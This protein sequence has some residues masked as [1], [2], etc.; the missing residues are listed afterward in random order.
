MKI[1]YFLIAAYVFVGLNFAPSLQ[2]VTPARW[3]VDSTITNNA[4]FPVT[5]VVVFNDPVG[6][7][8]LNPLWITL[9]LKPKEI[10]D[11]NL[12]RASSGDQPSIYKLARV[13][14]I[15]VVPNQSTKLPIITIL[16]ADND[17]PKNN[18]VIEFDKKNNKITIKA[19]TPAPWTQK[20][21][22]NNT[23]MPLRIG[24]MDLIGYSF[25]LNPKETKPLDIT[26]HL[27]DLQTY[28]GEGETSS[29]NIMLPDP[30]KYEAGLPI[31]ID[32]P[33]V[34]DYIIKSD[35]TKTGWPIVVE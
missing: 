28:S 20:N 23:D 1:R 17:A 2:A 19:V 7:K 11:L 9:E 21:I 31:K 12:S 3:M 29:L 18:Y 34:K 30:T 35:K 24:I 33:K 8:D 27:T 15:G 5:A 13:P 14:Q 10:H 4:P 25:L 26:K 32:N 22:T 6:N 16:R